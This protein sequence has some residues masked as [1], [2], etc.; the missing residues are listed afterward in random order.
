M[1]IKHYD[2]QGVV[3]WSNSKAHS[4]L[5]ASA[6][7]QEDEGLYHLDILSLDLQERSKHLNV[8][9][10]GYSDSAF[11]CVAW[12]N[13]GEKDAFSHGLIFTGM[14]NSSF[15]LWNP[16][17]MVATYNS[18]PAPSLDG[19]EW[20]EQEGIVIYE[21]ELDNGF[22][23][24]CGEWNSL[25]NHMLAF[26]TTDVF[27]LLADQDPTNPDLRKPGKKNPHAGS[28]VTSVS[29]NREVGHILAS[30]SENGLVALWDVKSNSSIF[31]FGGDTGGSGSRN[32]VICWSKSISTQ[33]AVTLDDEK[34]NKL[35]I[36][37]LRNQKGPVVV[38]DKCHSKGINAMDWCETDPELI[39]TASRDRKVVCWNYSQEEDEPLSQAV[40]ESQPL[41]VKWS[42]KLPSIY[43]VS[44]DSGTEVYSLSD[45][46]LFSYVPKWFKVPVGSTLSGS[47]AVLTYAE[48]RGNTLQENALPDYG[49][50]SP[51][52]PQLKAL[53]KIT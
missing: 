15:K 21:E 28:Y 12:D 5:L 46:N 27:I 25:N 52:R 26:G 30:A 38:I 9:G 16:A 45:A 32:V 22:P 34:S 6:S 35:Q 10:N 41:S 3:A 4:E 33:I 50:N 14:E 24:M 29:W 19:L 51:L 23:V 44:T 17:Q 1:K 36:W 8:I 13:F 39:L 47:N 20:Q 49:K 42:R 31:H 2:R 48:Q 7:F 40:L 37:D 18:R 43:S 53:S 11:R